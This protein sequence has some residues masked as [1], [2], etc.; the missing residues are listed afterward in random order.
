ME[1]TNKLPAA[2]E[3]MSMYLQQQLVEYMVI[4]NGWKEHTPQWETY[5]L[6]VRQI[7]KEI[8]HLEL[9][10]KAKQT[11]NTDTVE[12]SEEEF[13]E[14]NIPKML[15]DIYQKIDKSWNDED[16]LFMYSSGALAMLGE[17]DDSEMTPDKL[18]Q[19]E[20]RQELEEYKKTRS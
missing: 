10:E 16:M 15:W 5:D 1:D 13:T 6:V 19:T 12:Q 8:D 4:R 18:A 20:G 14:Q 11:P 2:I 7:A 17:P 9:L 3:S